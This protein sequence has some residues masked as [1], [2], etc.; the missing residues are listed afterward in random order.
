VPDDGDDI[1]F[2]IEVRPEFDMPEWKGLKLKQLTRVLEG[3]GRRWAD[4]RVRSIGAFEAQRRMA[5]I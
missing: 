4:A 2:T 5:I 3:R 1:E